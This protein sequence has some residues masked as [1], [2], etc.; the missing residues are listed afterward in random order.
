MVVRPVRHAVAHDDG[1][2]VALRPRQN[3]IVWPMA[4]SAC[5]VESG[6]ALRSKVTSSGSH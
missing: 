6:I 1:M 4:R 5:A 2:P 3:L